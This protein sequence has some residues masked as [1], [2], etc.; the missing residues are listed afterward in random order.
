MLNINNI[1]LTIGIINISFIDFFKYIKKNRNDY[2]EI[3]KK[4][5]KN[6]HIYELKQTYFIQKDNISFKH[7]ITY[8]DIFGFCYDLDQK[9]FYF[10]LNGELIYKEILMIDINTNSSFVPF[11]HIGGDCEIIFNSGDK[12][13]YESNYK[14]YGFVPLDEYGKNNYELSN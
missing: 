9:V 3:I 6:M 12:L 7:Y 8:G 10:Y 11:L 13:E 1:D 2:L 4:E 14:N 5:T